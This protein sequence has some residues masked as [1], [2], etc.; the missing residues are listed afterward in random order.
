MNN[1]QLGEL[2]KQI[3]NEKG[4]TQ[5]QLG[6]LAKVSVR[7]ISKMENGDFNVSIFAIGKVF[8]ALGE[9]AAIILANA[10]GEKWRIPLY[11]NPSPSGD[12]W[13]NDPENMASVRRGMEDI[14][15]GRCRAYSMDEIRNLLD[16]NNND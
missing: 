1:N 10:D 12:P 5:A 13:F 6:E 9:P 4:L 14:K 2:I 8:N 15:A 7:Q 16:P 11:E 3:R